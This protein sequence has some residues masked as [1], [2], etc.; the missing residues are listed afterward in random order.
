MGKRLL[1]VAAVIAFVFLLGCCAPKG[2]VKNISVG[3]TPPE[4]ETTQMLPKEEP[5]DMRLQS[6]GIS[7]GLIDPKYGMHGDVKVNGIPVLSLPL[8]ITGAPEDTA[9][10]AI[11]MDDPD[12]KPISGYN[13]V[14]WMAVNIKDKDISEDFS[15]TAKGEAVQGKNDFDMIG[16][17]GPTPPDK[18]HTYM[19]KAYA[20]DS[21]LK[22]KEG[23]SKEAFAEAIEG[24]VL[25][26]ATLEGLYQK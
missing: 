26:I 3:N 21:P 2:S 11:Y 22:L 18:D 23:F 12:A 14:H 9:V 24:H 20:L 7:N 25:S 5:P 16:Y 17:G 15:R 1:T 13:W 4:P 6:A 10:F 19:I 8:E